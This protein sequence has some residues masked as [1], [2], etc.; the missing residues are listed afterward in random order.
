MRYC[1]IDTE[2]C[3]LRPEHDIL[4]FGAILDDLENPLPLDELPRFHCYFTKDD[5]CGSAFALSMHPV[6][7]R[8][9]A[10]R[11]EGYDYLSAMKFGNLFKRF[12]VKHGY[13]EE[14]QKVVINV[15]GKC[16]AAS[17][18][19]ALKSKT[20]I[21]KHVIMRKNVLDP[22][23][24]YIEKGDER[25][26][27][28]SECKSRAGMPDVVAHNALDDAM[29]VVSLIRKK[30]IREEFLI[31]TTVGDLSRSNRETI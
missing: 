13:E 14:Q 7:F 17:D 28:L 24:L 23:I 20:D 4:E 31:G 5:Y 25:L 18:M 21:A 10:D 22:G 1:S 3:G 6:I 16:F 26:P 8:R 29:D 19:P 27:S 9:I 15:A 12:L 30:L 11:E 2:S